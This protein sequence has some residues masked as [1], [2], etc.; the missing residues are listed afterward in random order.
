MSRFLDWVR[1][2]PVLAWAG[3]TTYY[4]IVV[5]SHDLVQRPALKVMQTYGVEF[6]HYVIAA[7]LAVAL[8]VIISR[9]WSRIRVHHQARWVAWSGG[10]LLLWSLL[11]FSA[12]M[13]RS[14]ETIHYVQYLVLVLVLAAL[15]R[16]PLLAV[17][18]GTLCGLFDEGWQ[19]FYLHPGQPYFDFN[20]VVMNTTG[21]LQGAWFYSLFRPR[22]EEGSHRWGPWLAGWV[23]LLALTATLF[24]TGSLTVYRQDHGIALHRRVPPT[25]E[26]MPKYINTNGWGNTWVRLHPAVGLGFLFVLPLAILA[27]PPPTAA[28]LP[29][30]G[31]AG[32]GDQPA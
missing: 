20:D 14:V 17:L 23:A 8:G 32:M 10:M 12:L 26:N 30:E 15:L 19:F 18:V 27:L 25:S 13:V 22:D 7:M 16:N 24:A 28:I 2:N 3:A 4:V 31:A 11:V 6:M 5:V 21:A 9:I 29:E 1:A